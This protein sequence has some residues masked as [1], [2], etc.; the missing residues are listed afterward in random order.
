MIYSACFT[1]PQ[2]PFLTPQVPFGPE[3]ECY[4]PCDL[5]LVKLNSRKQVNAIG[6]A[7]ATASNIA[8]SS[9]QAKLTF[10][11]LSSS[12]SAESNVDLSKIN[13]LSLIN[14]PSSEEHEKHTTDII[15][16]GHCGIIRYEYNYDV[17]DDNECL[18]R[19]KNTQKI[20]RVSSSIASPADDVYFDDE[21][22]PALNS[23]SKTLSQPLVHDQAT[24]IS[25]SVFREDQQN[26]NDNNNNNNVNINNNNLNDNHNNLNNNQ[27]PEPMSRVTSSNPFHSTLNP[28]VKSDQQEPSEDTDDELDSNPLLKKTPDSGNS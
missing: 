23:D 12:S 25:I 4:S 11:S 6:T 15:S 16:A 2:I 7:P 1:D 28:V 19:E 3:D 24:A 13:S 8:T 18:K 21:S 10:S 26:S 5:S 17:D 20:T 22:F 9:K 27:Q 14:N